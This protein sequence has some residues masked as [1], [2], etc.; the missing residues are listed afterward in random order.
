MYAKAGVGNVATAA[1]IAVAMS[2]AGDARRLC[3]G[4]GGSLL[5]VPQ[6]FEL[7]EGFIFYLF[8]LTAWSYKNF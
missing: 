8:R 2:E 4:R 5:E 1:L 3:L 7:F 6:R